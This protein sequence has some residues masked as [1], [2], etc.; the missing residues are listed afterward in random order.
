MTQE[1]ELMSDC[2]ICPPTFRR[3]RASLAKL[4][5]HVQKARRFNLTLPACQ[6]VYLKLTSPRHAPSTLFTQKHKEAPRR[7]RWPQNRQRATKTR[8]CSKPLAHK[9][10]PSNKEHIS[11]KISRSASTN[12]VSSKGTSSRPAGSRRP[13]RK[14]RLTRLS[15]TSALT[16]PRLSATT[17]LRMFEG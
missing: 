6:K 14:R 16:A 10:Q 13:P 3:D 9:A 5:H 8:T 4:T 17:S 12:L 1:S 2:H 15:T 11:S 7:P